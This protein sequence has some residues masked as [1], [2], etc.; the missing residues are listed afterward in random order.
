[1]TRARVATYRIQ[2]RPEFGFEA[3]SHLVDYW[4]RLGISHLYT[5]PYLQAASGSAHG[6]DVVDHARVNEELGGDAGRQLLC[7]A[8]EARGLEQIIDIVPNH[9]AIRGGHNAWWWDVLENGP[10]SQFSSYFD[11]EWQAA[12]QDK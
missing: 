8:L 2:L 4:E 3:A 11:V 5:S 9:M 6:Y 1:M 7:S 12:E 10:S